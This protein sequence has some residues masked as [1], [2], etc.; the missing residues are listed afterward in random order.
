[1]KYNSLISDS[2][3]PWN[4]HYIVVIYHDKPLLLCSYQ[5][6]TQCCHNSLVS[7]SCEMTF[8]DLRHRSSHRGAGSS[9][10]SQE[11]GN[12]TESS[13]SCSPS[14]S[15][16]LAGRWLSQT[17][18]ELWSP[19]LVSC[20]CCKIDIVS[21]SLVSSQST[22]SSKDHSALLN[23]SRSRSSS[24]LYR[25]PWCES[26]SVCPSSRS[27]SRS[28]CTCPCRPCCAR[29]RSRG[30]AWSRVGPALWSRNSCSASGPAAPG[31]VAAGRPGARCRTNT[32]REEW[33]NEG[34]GG[35]T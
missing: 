26:S 24:W 16:C 13:A 1:M 7:P 18:V 29:G 28:W 30:R 34:W 8:P 23:H 35:G 19:F 22:W 11:W 17:W 14:C 15:A 27:C 4:I 20:F 3:S 31:W 2:I 32:C 12:Y 6:N 5:S 33:M 10:P 25:P 9:V 21:E